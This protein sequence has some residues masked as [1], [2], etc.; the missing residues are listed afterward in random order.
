MVR[1]RKKMVRRRCERERK[2][3]GRCGIERA[4]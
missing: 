3:E 4:Q 1:E 2:M